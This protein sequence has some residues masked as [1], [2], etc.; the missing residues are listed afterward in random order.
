M[1]RYVRESPIFLGLTGFLKRVK[2][3][4]PGGVSGKVLPFFFMSPFFILISVMWF[5]PVGITTY[6]AFTKTQWTI[7]NM[8]FIGLDNFVRIFTRDIRVVDTIYITVLYVSSVLAINAFFS[9]VLAI[10]TTYFIKKE[11][12][13]MAIR[14]AWLIPRITPAVI[15]ALLWRWFIDPNIGLLNTLLGSLGL[16][17]PRDWLLTPPYSQILMIAVNGYVGASFGMIIYSAAITSIPRDIFH[18][19]I[20]DG[21]TDLQVCRHIILPLLKWPIFFV[22]SWQCLSLISSYEHILALW[23]GGAG[24]ARAAEVEVWAL[25]AYSKAFYASE[26]GYGAALSIFLVAIGLIFIFIFFRVFGF[27]R[28]MQ[29]SKVEV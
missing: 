16:P 28:M 10:F 4:I 23:A 13:S 22:T 3:Y 15:Y 25:Y 1:K 5:A 2:R 24:V 14:L 17:T 29:P 21:A 18:A 26:Y 9:L 8:Q 11:P 19:A 12:I 6:M 20:A 27:E 7:T